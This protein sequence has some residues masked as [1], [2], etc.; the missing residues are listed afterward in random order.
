MEFRIKVSSQHRIIR[1]PKI[2]ADT[3][4]EDWTIVPGRASAVV[5]PSYADLGV[6][7][8]SLNR[9]REELEEQVKDTDRRR[10]ESNQ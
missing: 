6:V 1:V 4:G 3:F 9:I 2:L 5:Y 7:V 8:R 10:T